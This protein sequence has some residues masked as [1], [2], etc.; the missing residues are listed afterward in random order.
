M[1]FITLSVKTGFCLLNA[2]TFVS[3]CDKYDLSC[4]NLYVFRFKLLRTALQFAV[5]RWLA[6]VFLTSEESP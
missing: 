6:S 2:T 4:L 5:A 1:R 3:S